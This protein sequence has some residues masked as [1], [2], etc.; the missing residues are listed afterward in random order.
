MSGR[1]AVL[2]T[3]AKILGIKMGSFFRFQT[4]WVQSTNQ[5]CVGALVVTQ[6]RYCARELQNIPTEWTLG[7]QSTQNRCPPLRSSLLTQLG[8]SMERLNFQKLLYLLWALTQT[9]PHPPAHSPTG[10]VVRSGKV[11]CW[12]TQKQQKARIRQPSKWSPSTIL[13]QVSI[14]TIECPLHQG[15][16]WVFFL[17]PA[18][19]ADDAGGR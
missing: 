1:G 3:R 19:G 9:P 15:Q 12:R 2:W 7:T 8:T 5:Y 16:G 4:H 11:W 13:C 6:S 14:I 17:L 10:G 18:H